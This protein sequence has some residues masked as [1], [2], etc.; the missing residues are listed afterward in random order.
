MR[1]QWIAND[2][3]IQPPPEPPKRLT[4]QPAP[5]PADLSP[6]DWSTLGEILALTKRTI[7]SDGSSPPA[8]VLAVI[9]QALLDHFAAKA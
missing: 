3:P 9:R 4:Y 1:I 8:E 7:P 5:P 6:E 2:A